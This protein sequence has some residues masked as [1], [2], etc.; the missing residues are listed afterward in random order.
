MPFNVARDINEFLQLNLE[1]NSI[2]TIVDGFISDKSK[3][4]QYNIGVSGRGAEISFSES[5]KKL[6]EEINSFVDLYFQGGD[7]TIKKEIAPTIRKNIDDY[8]YYFQIAEEFYKQREFNSALTTY[9]KVIEIN[10]KHSWSYYKLGNIFR[11]QNKDDQAVT[12]YRKTIEINPDFSWSYYH[13]AT[14][15]EKQGK[16]EE[17]IAS[18][19]KAIELYP[20]FSI[21]RY[22][23]EKLLQ[24]QI[25]K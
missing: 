6:V 1:P 14:I 17:A 16:L 20:N 19:Q 25:F 8:E 23:L 21:C 2:D 24:Q 3:I 10:P 7:N 4:G 5:D 13:L 9:Q 12:A 22:K 11:E 15:L 18:Y